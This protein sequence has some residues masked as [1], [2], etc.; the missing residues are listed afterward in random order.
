[1]GK[2]GSIHASTLRAAP[3]GGEGAG[4][5]AGRAP[6]A[7]RLRV[8]RPQRARAPRRSRSTRPPPPT[9]ASRRAASSARSSCDDDCRLVRRQVR[10]PLAERPERRPERALGVVLVERL[11]DVRHV[12]RVDRRRQLL[13]LAGRRRRPRRASG[14]VEVVERRRAR[15]RPSRRRS[16]GC[17]IASSSTSARD[18]RGLRQR[19]VGDRALHAQR[20]VDGQRVD[21]QP[22]ER[23]HQRGAG[24]AVERDALLDLR[25]ARGAYLSRKTSACGWPEPSTG[26]RLP[27]GQCWQACRSRVKRVELADR[28][29]EVLLADLVVGGGHSGRPDSDAPAGSPCRVHQDLRRSSRRARRDRALDAAGGRAARR[30]GSPCVCRNFSAC[31]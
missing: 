18:A 4:R 20:P 11:V 19:R 25:R 26:I 17:T 6:R 5:A 15:P 14:S 3:A 23:L 31:T 8:R 29:L 21:V 30:A 7:A 28:A 12:Q 10:V 9:S 27:R 22:L 24:A 13:E 16:C 2:R 1:M